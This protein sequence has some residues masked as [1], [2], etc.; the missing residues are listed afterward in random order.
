MR[1]SEK[2]RSD[3]MHLDFSAKTGLIF[4]II[5]AADESFDGVKPITGTP[6]EKDII[7]LFRQVSE[8]KHEIS[9]STIIRISKEVFGV[10][11]LP[12]VNNKIKKC[13]IEYISD[14]IN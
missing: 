10:K 6:T 1:D 5:M 4:D 2:F 14:V 11:G 13:V 12:I 3:I 8:V 9:K 7:R